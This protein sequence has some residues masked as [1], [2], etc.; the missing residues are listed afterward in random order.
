MK[1]SKT[2][3]TAPNEIEKGIG[4]AFL[5]HSHIKADE[6][7]FYASQSKGSMTIESDEFSAVNPQTA[8]PETITLKIQYSLKGKTLV[9]E[10]L[11]AYLKSFRNVG[12]N[13]DEV[14][15][16]IYE[17]IKKTIGHNQV[18]VTTFI[19]GNGGLGV[20]C[21]ESSSKGLSAGY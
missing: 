6:L 19:Q 14:T 11:Y 4:I 10:S 17:D 9:K 15:L 5:D 13:Q 12:I 3:T 8:E 1:E 18:T 16:T 21:T 2:E 20:T 7:K